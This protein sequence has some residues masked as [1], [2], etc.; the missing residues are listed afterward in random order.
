MFRKLFTSEIKTSFFQSSILISGTFLAQVVT[1]LAYPILTRLFSVSEFG[2]LSLFLSITSIISIFVTARM[3][4]AL[5]LPKYDSEAEEIFKIG[6]YWCFICSILCLCISLII[7]LLNFG[8][9]I[10]G[11]Y[12]ISFTGLTTGL[13]QLLTFRKN[14]QKNYKAIARVS[15]IQNFF[16]TG[17]KLLDGFFSLLNP[18][19]II[20]NLIGLSVATLTIYDKSLKTIFL[21]RGIDWK[22]LNKYSG[23]P[24]YRLPQALLNSFSTSLP[25]FF[26]TI[27][28][29]YKEAGYFSIIFGIALNLVNMVSSSLY[30]VLYQKITSY[31][32]ENLNI[33]SFY[34]RII[35]IL[36][37]IAFIPACIG[38]TFSKE[39]VI[40]YF[41]KA[42]INSAVYLRIIIPWLFLVFIIS[43][44]SFIAD[45][46][47]YQKKTFWIDITS[48]ILRLS[49]L[50][51]GYFFN[52]ALISIFLYALGSLCIQIYLF[53]WYRWILLNI[54]NTELK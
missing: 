11:L 3:E 25:I 49:G 31:Y 38:F 4:Y 48:L 28:Y 24:K 46:F 18:G 39:V 10:P 20:G 53:F 29:S 33:Y 1:I 43:P 34:K 15:V 45:I 14:R 51:I 9:K 37:I 17:F 6:V 27:Y 44:F 32:H 26:L 52:N 50:Y 36:F 5:I 47:S 2:G 21:K 22:I 30:Q 19:L 23:F 16:S 8:H 42:W 35:I 13:L 41:G 7:G 12:L 54:Y 40:L